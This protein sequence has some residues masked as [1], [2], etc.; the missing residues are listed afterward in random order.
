MDRL[1]CVLFCYIVQDNKWRANIDDSAHIALFVLSIPNL[2][3]SIAIMTKRT[4]SFCMAILW[5]VP[6]AALFAYFSSIENQGF[7][8][9]I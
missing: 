3:L 2:Y 1:L 8:V 6:N 5:I 7:Q 9:K 4:A